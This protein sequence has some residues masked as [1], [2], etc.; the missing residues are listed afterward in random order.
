MT[1][2]QT[3]YRMTWEHQMK[4]TQQT[5]RKLPRVSRK[6]IAL[7]FGDLVGVAAIFTLFICFL[8]FTA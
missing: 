7:F 8:V 2:N 4:L 3:P 1:G 5:Q 6:R